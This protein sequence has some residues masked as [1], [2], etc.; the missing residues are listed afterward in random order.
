VLEAIADPRH[1]IV[2]LTISEGGSASPLPIA[3]KMSAV[4]API[5]AGTQEIQ[6]SVT[7]TY[8]AA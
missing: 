5:E 8:S 4:G 6:A 1:K 3:N 7:I 2:T